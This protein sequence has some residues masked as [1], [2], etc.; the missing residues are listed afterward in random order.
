MP[1]QRTQCQVVVRFK[2]RIKELVFV[3]AWFALKRNCGENVC[4]VNCGEK[5][6]KSAKEN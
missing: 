2:M 5:K 4:L 1:I 3:R 6:R